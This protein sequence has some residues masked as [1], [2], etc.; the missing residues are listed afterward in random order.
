L[1]LLGEHHRQQQGVA[2]NG[3]VAGHGIDVEMR[4]LTNG[5]ATARDDRLQTEREGFCT[6]STSEVSGRQPATLVAC[7]MD[8]SVSRFA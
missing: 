5:S 4:C 3:L 7:P 6:A 8:R 2:V 1:D